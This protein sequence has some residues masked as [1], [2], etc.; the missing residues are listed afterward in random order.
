MIDALRAG[1]FSGIEAEGAVIHARLW[2][3]SVE[4]TATE[5]GGLWRLA[6]QWPLRASADQRATWTAA[7]PMAPMDIHLGETR[8]SFLAEEGDAAALAQ[9]AALA[10]EAVA[11]M[12]RWRRAQRIPGEGM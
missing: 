5:E 8:V 9:W 3:S 11:Q 12:I 2:A 4:F 6:L 7:H 10:E 1:G